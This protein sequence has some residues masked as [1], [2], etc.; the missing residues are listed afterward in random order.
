MIDIIT[1][2]PWAARG[3]S[4]VRRVLAAWARKGALKRDYRHLMEANEHFL[5]DIGLTRGDIRDAIHGIITNTS[6]HLAA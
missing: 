3:L 5:R 1:K 2:S 4:G 6:H